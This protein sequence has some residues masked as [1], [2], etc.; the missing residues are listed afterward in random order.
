V[1]QSVR[2]DVACGIGSNRMPVACCQAIG[3]CAIGIDAARIGETA[4]V[5]VVAVAE[6]T[7]RAGFGCETVDC[8]VGISRR[9]ERGGTGGDVC[10][11][12]RR[13]GCRR[14]Q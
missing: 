6:V 12:G 5:G 3:G 11:P 13:S 4:A 14:R 7:D 9:A 2:S 8:I 1:S 10:P